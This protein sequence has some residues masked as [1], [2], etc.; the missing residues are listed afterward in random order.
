MSS[1]IVTSLMLLAFVGCSLNRE[2]DDLVATQPVGTAAAAANADSAVSPASATQEGGAVVETATGEGAAKS[3]VKD[4]AVIIK[5][6]KGDIKAVVYAT[7]T[8][9]TAASFLNLA[10]R[11]YYDGLTFHRV[12]PSFMIQGGDPAGT[13]SGG[14]GYNFQDETLKE[15]K[16]D[17]PGIL[18]MANSDRGKR[19]YSNSGKSNGS[20]FFVTHTPTPHLDGLHTVFGA[21]NGPADQKV[22][23]AI[24]V[25][26]T[27][28][29]VEIVDKDAAEA[30]FTA[31]AAEIQDWNKVLDRRKR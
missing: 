11:G 3:E 21:V 16:H 1:R 20:Q 6:S 31:R 30:L 25:G 12:I 17:K 2:S 5:T 28:E 4:V 9:R 15:L 13:G 14:P 26:D 22:V 8:P 27:I 10:K 29:T 7:K 18:S 24:R 19:P 23:D